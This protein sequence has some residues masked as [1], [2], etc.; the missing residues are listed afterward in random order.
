MF[1]LSLY[2]Y[3]YVFATNCICTS[4]CIHVHTVKYTALIWGLST[5]KNSQEPCCDVR[6]ALGDPFLLSSVIS[7]NAK[8]L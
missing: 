1:Y 4:V 2:V 3:V 8:S 5:F 6:D 7:N